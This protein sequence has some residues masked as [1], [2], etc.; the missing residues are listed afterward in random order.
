MQ[1]VAE[2]V[3]IFAAGTFDFAE[4]IKQIW[5]PQTQPDAV[6]TSNHLPVEGMQDVQVFDQLHDR[7]PVSQDGDRLAINSHG[8]P[9]SMTLHDG[10]GTLELPHEATVPLDTANMQLS[11]DMDAVSGSLQDAVRSCY[12]CFARWQ[13]KSPFPPCLPTLVGPCEY[14]TRMQIHC[15]MVRCTMGNR[16]CIMLRNTRFQ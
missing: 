2:A 4:S 13:D 14:C 3:Q 9:P 8:H 7:T 1:A 5:G 12:E 15:K 6:E 11:N 16:G 10:E